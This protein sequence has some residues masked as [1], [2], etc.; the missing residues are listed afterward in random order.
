MNEVVMSGVIRDLGALRFTPAGE[1]V[2]EFC[3]RHTS[4]QQEAG[5]PRRVAL[6]LKAIAIGAIAQ[7]LTSARPHE[8]VTAR[9]FLAAR[10]LRDGEL[11]L[12]AKAI[13]FELMER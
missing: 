5:R 10:S 12:H 4:M 1:P 6:D 7:R 13:E 2:A 9:G 11:V 3:L 8:E